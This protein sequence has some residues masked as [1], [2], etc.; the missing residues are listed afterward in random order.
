[1]WKKVNEYITIVMATVG[2]IC[3][4]GATGS[5]E[6]DRYLQGAS[7]AVLGIAS[8]ILALYSQE[9]YKEDK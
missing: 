4:I 7:M 9:L 6:V 5:I 2:T 3:M 8:Y 1:M